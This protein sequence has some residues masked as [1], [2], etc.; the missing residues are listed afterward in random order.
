MSDGMVPRPSVGWPLAKAA[1]ALALLTALLAGFAC[2]GTDSP[3][4]QWDRDTEVLPL[5]RVT[6]GAA[7]EPRLRSVVILLPDADG[8]VG[9]IE[10]TNPSGSATLTRAREAVAFEELDRPFIADDQQIKRTDQPT[11]DAEP[12]APEGFT[13]Y[14]SL[15][16]ALLEPGSEAAWAATVAALRARRIPEVTIVAHTDRVGAEARNLELSERRAAAIRDALVD[17]GLDAALLETAWYGETRPAVPTE[18]GVAERLNRRAEI[19]V[20]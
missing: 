14:F 1:G 4:W 15:G 19:R 2:A 10:V 6:T 16:S 20:R 12:Q 5:K 9:V 8:G 17:A 13:V 18:D 3:K 7:Q 11:L